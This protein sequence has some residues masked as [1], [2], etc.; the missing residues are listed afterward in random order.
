[1][2]SVSLLLSVPNC[3]AFQKYKLFLLG[4]NKVFLFTTKR[5]ACHVQS[6]LCTSCFLS[7]IGPSF[8]IHQQMASPPASFTIP[9]LVT[10]Y[11]IFI[12]WLS[13]RSFRRKRTESRLRL[14]SSPR[15]WGAGP[16]ATSV[17]PCDWGWVDFRSYSNLGTAASQPSVERTASVLKA[18]RKKKQ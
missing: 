6:T 7:E 4:L 1:M 13:S 8:H 5:K 10:A 15:S 11:A 14:L 9:V 17:L 16:A 18:E 3:Y 12:F 2:V